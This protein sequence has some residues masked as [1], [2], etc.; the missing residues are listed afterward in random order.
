M[1]QRQLQLDAMD[2]EGEAVV[3]DRCLEEKRNW[4]PELLEYKEMVQ[5]QWEGELG[6]DVVV[7]EVLEARRRMVVEARLDRRRLVEAM[8]DRLRLEEAEARAEA[9]VAQLRGDYTVLHGEYSVAV[10]R[11]HG[12][13]AQSAQEAGLAR[14]VQ[15][16][17][18]N[19]H[20]RLH[21]VVSQN[22]K[23]MLQTFWAMK[24]S[25]PQRL[26]D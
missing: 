17:V 11:A 18:V 4:A 14:A 24:R 16:T 7:S 2:L 20:A 22:L 5:A 13:A 15:D 26:V 10:E 12:W 9:Q 8:K 23:A 3:V 19:L 1:V 25:T 21:V 6:V